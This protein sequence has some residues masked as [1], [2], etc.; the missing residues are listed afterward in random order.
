VFIDGEL[1]KQDGALVGLDRRQLVDEATAA[2]NDLKQRVG[3]S[4]A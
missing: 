4:M 3:V 2:M 1:R